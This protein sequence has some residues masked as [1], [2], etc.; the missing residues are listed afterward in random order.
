MMSD[1]DV[2][3]AL[4]GATVL[5]AALAENGYEVDR[6]AI[7]KWKGRDFIPW[8]WRGRVV[9]LASKRGVILPD[10]FFDDG[11]AEGGPRQP[12]PK[13]PGELQKAS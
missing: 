13:A 8:K 7:Y 11:K 1:T 3:E 12:E 6:E 9:A 2:I 5:A 10:D 4:G